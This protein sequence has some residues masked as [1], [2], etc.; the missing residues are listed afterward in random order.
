MQPSR[1]RHHKLAML[2]LLSTLATMILATAYSLVN[3]NAKYAKYSAPGMHTEVWQSY[4]LHSETR[5][6]S[7]TANRVLAGEATAPELIQRLGVA[8]SQLAPLQNT[9]VFDYLPEAHT[10]LPKTLEHLDSLLDAWSSR[11]SWQDTSLATQVASEM[12]D[13]LP[14]MLG[15]T[16]DIIVSANIAVASRLDGERQDLKRTFQRLVWVLLLLGT[17]SLLLAAKLFRDHRHTLHLTREL[18]TL[19]QSLE[20]RVAERTRRLEERKALLGIILDSSPSD[21]ALLGANDQHA[22]YISDTLRQRASANDSGFLESLFVDSH[23]YTLFMQRLTS[24]QAF[25]NWEARLDPRSPYWALLSVRHLEIDS[26]RAW[27]IWS[28]DI[29]ERKRM[30]HELKQLATTDSLTGLANRRTF[31]RQAIKQLRRSLRE[32]KPCSV[33]VIDIDNFKRINDQHGHQVGDTVLQAVARRLDKHLHPRGPLGRLGGEEFAALVKDADGRAAWEIAEALRDD[34]ECLTL[35]GE[36]G[37][38]IPVTISIGIATHSG[39]DTS[40]Q[41]LLVEADKA[42]YLAKSRGRNR[43]ETLDQSS[44]APSY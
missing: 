39:Q 20:E 14:S 44:P 6:L 11:L 15:P 1:P 7:D 8:M 17:G 29:S 38:A 40:P 35:Q 28:L 31:L 27:L 22:Y 13:Q 4:Q 24:S 23:Q 30:E 9:Q 5:R 12:A 36:E 2:A 37:G 25:D 10:E 33:L 3:V 34:V 32:A 16:H 43:C 19:N 21:V 42:L 18:G 41:H 26:R